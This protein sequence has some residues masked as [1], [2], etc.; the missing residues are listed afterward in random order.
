VTVSG[1]GPRLVTMRRHRFR[2]LAVGGE[3]MQAPEIWVA[4]VR[5]TPIVDML[6]GEDWLAGKRV[7]ISYATRQVFVA[8]SG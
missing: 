5:F 6:L 7:W 1:Q 3:T 8:E 2:S 4:P